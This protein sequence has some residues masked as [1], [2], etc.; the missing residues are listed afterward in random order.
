M[1][2]GNTVQEQTVN[3]KNY[4]TAYAK[5]PGVVTKEEINAVNKMSPAEWLPAWWQQSFNSR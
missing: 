4:I 3:E 5:K 2:I 1:L